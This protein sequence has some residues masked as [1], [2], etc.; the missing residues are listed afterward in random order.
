VWGTRRGWPGRLVAVALAA[1]AVVVVAAGVV[2]AILVRHHQQAAQ[3]ELRPSGIPAS[4][5]TNLANLMVLSP[6][7]GTPAPGFSLTGQ[8]GQHIELSAFRG[9]VVVLTFMDSRCVNI[10]PLVAQEFV[11]A[12]HDLGRAAGKVAFVAVN[13][14]P[15]H[16]RVQDVR[17]FSRE[18][19]LLAIPSWQFVTG[20]V[21]ALQA[22]WR[23]YGVQVQAA[24]P[25]ADIVHT[26][27]VYFIGRGGAERFIATPMGRQA[28]NGRAYLPAG[29][30]AAW[31]HGITLVAQY[32][33]R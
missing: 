32:L 29:Q 31:G 30:L 14:N 26:S 13:V 25:N 12:Y 23:D 17:A 15:Y 21:A 28:A 9:K 20:P 18:H 19:Q 8:N 22:V 27:L 2:L 5:S 6:V 3:A 33:A 24:G 11:D 1:A 4:V 7:P 10:C 16:A